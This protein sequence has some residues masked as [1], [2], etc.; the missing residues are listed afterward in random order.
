[1]PPADTLPAPARTSTTLP[2]MVRANTQ[3]ARKAGPLL[4]ARLL[5]NIKITAMIGIGLI[6]TPIACGKILPIAY[7]ISLLL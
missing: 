5:N 2:T 6:A 7:P 1:V 4:L 3:P